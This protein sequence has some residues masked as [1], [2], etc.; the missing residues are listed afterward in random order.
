MILGY[1]YFRKPPFLAS[2]YAQVCGT[3]H[4]LVVGVLKPTNITRGHHS[5]VIPSKK[6]N[7][8]VDYLNGDLFCAFGEGGFTTR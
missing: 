1:P 4:E 3:Y 6:T 5:V 2:K 8:N 7:L